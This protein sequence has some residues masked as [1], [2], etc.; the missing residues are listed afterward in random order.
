MQLVLGVL[1]VLGGACQKPAGPVSLVDE[2]NYS[3]PLPPGQLALRKITDPARIPDFA[4]G[5]TFRTGLVEA[6]DRSL[7][8]LAK[9]SSQG[10][11]PYGEITHQHAVA[12]L[13]AFREVLSQARSPDDLDRMIRERFDV[14]ESV[15]YDG[16]GIVFFTGYYCPIFDA[17]LKR[18]AEFAYPLYGLPDDLVKD[19]EGRCK[20][21][22]MPDGGVAPGYY[23][24][25]EIETTRPLAGREIAWLRDPF[26]AYI[27]T[28]QGSAKLRMED[29]RLFEIGYV[30]NNGREYVPIGPKLVEDGKIPEN[31]LS[32]RRMIDFFKLYP[33]E[34]GYYTHMNPRYVFFAPRPGG[35]FGSLNEVVTP[36]RS[37]ATD[38]EVYPRACVAFLDTTLPAR[39][40]EQIVQN[41]YQA[42]ALDQ[43]TGGAIRAPGRCDLF[44]GTGDAQ[45]EL[46]GRT[47]AEGRLYYLF[48][49]YLPSSRTFE[50]APAAG[51]SSGRPTAG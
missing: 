23:D 13:Q 35:P 19:S 8:Y 45:G 29:G 31:E 37:I 26:E 20:G 33:D 24:R 6:V 27:V 17:R 42:F 11:F 30:A 12:S 38:K 3:A 34:V 32:L 22:R 49:K 1:L 4:P 16:A 39:E 18:D 46:A 28:V 7:H 50:P 43:D 15:G 25:Q 2:P 5:F 40:S 48:L 41:A 51:P 9:P 10:Y 21:R 36:Y 44:L 47:A 14:Y